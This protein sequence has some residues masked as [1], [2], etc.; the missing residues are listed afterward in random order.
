MRSKTACALFSCSCPRVVLPSTSFFVHHISR[1]MSNV[2]VATPS[3]FSY[4]RMTRP[5]P[6]S[7]FVGCFSQHSPEFSASA[8]NGGVLVA[9]D[10]TWTCEPRFITYY[11]MTKPHEPYS[12]FS[13]AHPIAIMTGLEN[14][15]RRSFALYGMIRRLSIW[16]NDDPE[17]LQYVITVEVH[18]ESG[19][20][21]DWD[22]TF[23]HPS[24]PEGTIFLS[25]HTFQAE[26]HRPLSL[27]SVGPMQVPRIQ[28][29]VERLY[30]RVLADLSPP[31]YGCPLHSQPH[32]VTVLPSGD[33]VTETEDSSDVRTPTQAH[34]SHPVPTP[35][36]L[37]DRHRSS[38]PLDATGST[39]TPANVTSDAPA[40]QAVD[41]R[42]TWLAKPNST[43]VPPRGRLPR[44][45]PRIPRHRS[46]RPAMPGRRVWRLQA[47]VDQT[48]ARSNSAPGPSLL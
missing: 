30:Q 44:D 17:C 7:I 11:T 45:R 33:T 9:E 3:V 29:D 13:I 14:C 4:P 18:I 1:A 43:T 41:I 37:T 47:D 38:T 23:P 6:D 22:R 8:Q 48:I 19:M 34:F 24:P 36:A 12:L 31:S 39:S 28:Y 46:T 5:Y 16:S 26:N 32:S 27:T 21:L 2:A 35:L 20:E 40:I 10:G 42:S 15:C 25:P